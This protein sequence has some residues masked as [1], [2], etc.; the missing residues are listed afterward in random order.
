[1]QAVAAMNP[2]L[3]CLLGSNENLVGWKEMGLIVWGEIVL[4]VWEETSL[5]VRGLE[6]LGKVRAGVEI[7]VLIRLLSEIGT[8]FM[9]NIIAL[10]LGCS[11]VKSSPAI[12]GELRIKAAAMVAAKIVVNVFF[13][14]P[15]FIS[16]S[17]LF[18]IPLFANAKRVPER[19][20]SYHA[21]IKYVRRI[22]SHNGSAECV[23]ILNTT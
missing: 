10:P 8:Y 20:I 22:L 6:L 23:H 9:V 5:R 17:P 15:F 11:L 16:L 21:V 13:V 4:I 19:E 1:M 3:L 18:F 2:P 7:S 14:C 12:I